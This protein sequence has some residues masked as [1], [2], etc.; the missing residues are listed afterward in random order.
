[1]S[2]H[3]SNI[4]VQMHGCE[5]IRVATAPATVIARHAAKEFYT[6]GCANA[7]VMALQQHSSDREIV[8]RGITALRAMLLGG[9]FHGRAPKSGL[10]LDPDFAEIIAITAQK[11]SLAIAAKDRDLSSAAVV[12]AM[13]VRS[14]STP[15]QKDP[16]LSQMGRRIMRRIRFGHKLNFYQSDQA[17]NSSI[18]SANKFDQLFDN[19]AAKPELARTSFATRELVRTR[20]VAERQASRDTPKRSKA[21]HNIR[22]SPRK[23]D[24]DEQQ[25][26]LTRRWR[27]VS[28]NRARRAGSLDEAVRMTRTHARAERKPP[29]ALTGSEVANLSR[30]PSNVF[31]GASPKPTRVVSMDQRVCG[32]TDRFRRTPRP[33]MSAQPIIR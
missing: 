21:N 27:S 5:L 4:P 24:N 25:V 23:K 32:D 6:A 14:A 10:Q 31:G 2:R 17:S 8:N 7:V 3:T 9:G 16:S 26:T 29:L 20:T 11:V 15:S 13:D 18:Y 28:A 12:L 30:Q 22:P 33:R 19:P 1:M